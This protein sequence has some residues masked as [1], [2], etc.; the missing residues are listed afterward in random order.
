MLLPFSAGWSVH[1]SMYE[2]ER[3]RRNGA[4]QQ[5][6][7]SPVLRPLQRRQD[8]SPLVPFEPQQFTH[9]LTPPAPRS[10]TPDLGRSVTAVQRRAVSPT[11]QAAELNREDQLAVRH[12]SE[13][14]SIHRQAFQRARE[15]LDQRGLTPQPLHQL[16]RTTPA[17]ETVPPILS[18]IDHQERT[19]AAQ[20]EAVALLTR[21]AR[22]LPFHSRA[23]L[24]NRAIETARTQGLP[25]DTLR[26][27]VLSAV[28]DPVQRDTL[29]GVFLRH[30]QGRLKA[31]QLKENHELLIKHAQLQR[32]ADQAQGKHDQL[33]Q[34]SVLERVQARRAQGSPLPEDV[35]LQLELGLNHDLSAVRVHT[36]DEANRIAKSLQAVAFTSGKDIYFQSGE[37][38]P[39]AKLELLAHEAAHVKQQDRGQVA[40]GVD[41]DASLEAE[42]QQFGEDFVLGQSSSVTPKVRQDT[43]Q[44]APTS[45]PGTAPQVAV[46]QLAV[47]RQTDPTAPQNFW[48][49]PTWTHQFTGTLETSQITMTLSR[50]G[51]Q[52]SGRYQ[53][54]GHAGSLSLTGK[55]SVTSNMAT[56]TELDLKS[57]AGTPGVAQL[58]LAPDSAT[59]VRGSWVS[60]GKNL[61]ILLTLADG[62]K[63]AD[64]P[65]PN[66]GEVN[67]AVVQAVIEA[68]NADAKLHPNTARKNNLGGV[69]ADVLQAGITK[70]ISTALEVGE[71]D[72]RA[73]A[74]LI[75]NIAQESGFDAGVTESLYYTPKAHPENIFKSAFHGKPA[76]AQPYLRDSEKMAN[77]VYANRNG[78][79]NEASGDGYKFRGSGLIQITGR[80]NFQL[81]NQI[82][83]DKGWTVNG[84]LPDFT[85]NPELTHHP[86]ASYRIAVYGVQNGIFTGARELDRALERLPEEPSA[87]QFATLRSRYVGTHDPALAGRVAAA[88]LHAILKLPLRV[89]EAKK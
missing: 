34:H 42:A 82:F 55:I 25:A 24:A 61:P 1:Y 18:S 3:Q 5:R 4:G 60:A 8:G 28:S 16:V 19:R 33:T 68:I 79:G 36:D 6:A 11:L 73:I 53:Y 83:K 65:K 86:E 48:F 57:P 35:R 23:E 76:L 72:P 38:N 32:A 49:A 30:D 87:A 69:Q 14:L 10:L 81:W 75:A 63:K 15:T 29:E 56:L 45:V 40:P 43:E 67:P 77:H 27:H 20:Q 41:L 7:V 74:M 59:V 2:S 39:A 37:Y 44:A 22:A 46:P 50:S 85:L 89:A 78:N 66:T 26:Q 51:P 64:A 88:I 71:T 84:K 54:Q 62:A 17:H 52:V 70:T 21:D 58:I 31:A 80:S 13:H 47:Q 9:P 12:S